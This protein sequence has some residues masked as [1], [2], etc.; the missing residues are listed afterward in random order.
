MTTLAPLQPKRI[1]P[2]ATGTDTATG[3][4]RDSICE[5]ELTIGQGKDEATI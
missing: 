1:A 3:N 2:R 5:V 4:D